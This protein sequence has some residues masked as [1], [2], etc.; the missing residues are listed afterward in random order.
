[1]RLLL[2]GESTKQPKI[3]P[4]AHS[5]VSVL[6][7][8]QSPWTPTVSKAPPLWES[9]T[10]TRPLHNHVRTQA[11]ARTLSKPPKGPQVPILLIREADP[12][13]LIPTSASFHSSCLQKTQLDSLFSDSIQLRAKPHSLNPPKKSPNQSPN[14]IKPSNTLLLRCPTTLNSVW[15]SQL[16]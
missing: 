14:P 7:W 8:T 13:L 6:C 16:Q 3:G 2:H 10:K 9:Q 15:S 1:M 11:K 12:I 4:G 5:H